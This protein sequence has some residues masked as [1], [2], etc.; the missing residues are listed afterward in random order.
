M[1]FLA[2]ISVLKNRGLTAEVVIVDIVFKN[3]QPLKDRVYPAY[4][5]TRVNDPS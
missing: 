3:N 2:E 5:Y 4:L 1:I